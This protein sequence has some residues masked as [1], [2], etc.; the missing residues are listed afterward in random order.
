[1]KSTGDRMRCGRACFCQRFI[2]RRSW[3]YFTVPVE[4][5]I[6]YSTIIPANKAV[7]STKKKQ[8]Q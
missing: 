7:K 3:M 1:M 4:N 8:Y 2:L 5:I 6:K